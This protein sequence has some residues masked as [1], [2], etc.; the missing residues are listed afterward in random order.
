MSTVVRWNPFRD[1]INMRN[2]FDRLFDEVMDA[3]RLRWQEPT[4]WGL[5]LDVVE[6]ED[7]FLI[8]ASVPGVNPD[9]LD[10]TISDNVLTIKGELKEDQT[11]EQDRYHLRERRFGT[12]ARSVTLPVPV[13]ADEIDATYEHG[14][15]SL[16]V[17]KAEEIKPKRISI[18]AGNGAKV[19]EAQ[20][21]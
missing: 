13:N 8:K 2:E 6:N 17:P 15:L 7:N 1:M 9:D 14:I 12:F 18:K 5:A 21:N 16:N 4:N 10:I 20:S 19:L 3:P 11:V